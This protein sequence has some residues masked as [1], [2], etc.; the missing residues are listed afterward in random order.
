M[1][2]FLK[3]APAPVASANGWK[4]RTAS[5]GFHFRF[6]LGIVALL[7]SLIAVALSSSRY[8][9]ASA[10][11]SINGTTGS[12]AGDDGCYGAGSTDAIVEVQSGAVFGD[13]LPPVRCLSD[14]YPSFNSVAVDP[15]NDVVVM[16][17]INR[18]S[19]LVYDRRSGG[20][21]KEATPPRQQ[22]MG[23]KTQVGFVAGVAL[24]AANR[25]IFAVNNDIED[26]MMV[27]SYD[28]EGNINP[29]RLLAVPHQSW[30]LALGH[31]LD[32]IALTVESLDAIVFYRR[33]ADKV[34][35]P[36][37]SIL[38]LHTG[39]ADPHGLVLDEK[40]Q[41]IIV[42][43]HGNWGEGDV[44]VGE[45]GETSGGRFQPPSVS[46][47]DYAAKGDARPIRTI[48]GDKTLLDWPMGANVDSVNDEILVANNGQNSILIFE[49]TAAGNVAPKR[50]IRGPKTGI[51]LP[52]GVAVD[53]AH[54]EI[55][56]ANFGDHNALVFDA[57]A[58]G[59]VSPKRIVRN[60]PAG[61]PVVGFGNP[62]AAAYDTKR[63]E[64]LVPN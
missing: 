7:G 36:T 29:K 30:G 4:L 42:T 15:K 14:P 23:P 10:E 46:V 39:L 31:S 60:A 53:N 9:E 22:I 21:S 47:F 41:E 34:E 61:T 49:R 5:T 55:W 44:S 16:G 35:P 25:E 11:H 37:R 56:V 52:M 17:D 38:G 32:E 40:N 20:K 57:K 6:T 26:T 64:I 18:K 54:N 19:L 8:V 24:D 50:S 45:I 1:E 3:S 13:D 33:T 12:Y 63:Q 27:F 62:M 51:S 58:S 48:A 43:N 2:S 28:D 59:N